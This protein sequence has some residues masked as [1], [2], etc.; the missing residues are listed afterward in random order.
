MPAADDD[1]LRVQEIAQHPA[2]RKQKFEIQRVVPPHHR[3]I[4]RR[5]RSGQ[6]I[7]AATTDVQGLRLLAQRQS[8][9]TVDHRFALSKPA[10]L[11]APSKK[12]FS[13]VNSPIFAWRDFKS[14]VGFSEADRDSGP[15]TPAAPSRSCAFHCVI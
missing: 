15:N 13:S 4:G 12:S 14:A 10:L 1:A 11:S 8:V 3:E 7:D 6:V 9:L 2:T 5:N